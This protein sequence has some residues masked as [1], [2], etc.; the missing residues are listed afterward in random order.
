[1]TGLESLHL[2]ENIQ[3]SFT[4]ERDWLSL[5]ENQPW[6]SLS[7]TAGEFDMLVPYVGSWCWKHKNNVYSVLFFNCC[8]EIP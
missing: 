6:I 2:G 4:V 3:N 1:V 5:H 7:V 8:D